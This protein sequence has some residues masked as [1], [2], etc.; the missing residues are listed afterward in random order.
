MP[1]SPKPRVLKLLH[2][3]RKDRIND[4]EP[5]PR[6]VLPVCPDDA[7][8][9]T[10]AIWDYTLKELIAMRTAAAP[11]RDALYAY[12]CAVVTH[13]NAV[14]LV[15]Q[16]G[17]LMKGTSGIPVKNPAVA[18]ARDAAYTI[19]LFAH[20]F[21]LTPS[22]RTRIEVDRRATSAAIDNPFASSG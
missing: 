20:E 5:I 22:A 13:R 1:P 3:D 12:C 9:E 16:T 2:G 6:D 10:R 21:G 4:N 14:H 15:D 11:D 8:D 7:S 17:L 19:R 18:M